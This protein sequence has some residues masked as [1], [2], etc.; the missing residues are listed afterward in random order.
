MKKVVKDREKREAE[1]K[2]KLEKLVNKKMPIDT[3][4]IEVIQ[5]TLIKI[6]MD[7]DEQHKEKVKIDID[8]YNKEKY[9]RE[10]NTNKLGMK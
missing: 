10:L 9:D 2:L 7:I 4:N 8:A 1:N 3:S 5:D 6:L